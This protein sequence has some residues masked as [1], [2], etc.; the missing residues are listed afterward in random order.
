MRHE[1]GGLR[2]R[3]R[4]IRDGRLRV[5]LRLQ[6]AHNAFRT[7]PLAPV[8]R[9]DRRYGCI[10]KLLPVELDVGILGLERAPDMRI[11]RLAT[12]PHVGRRPEPVEDPL[13][14]FAAATGHG[15]DQI[16]VLVAAPI[17]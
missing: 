15:L 5:F 17:S 13:A 8:I 2:L 1:V 9:F 11:K 3:S 12:D 14:G 16:E 10:S 7:P 4:R 6:P